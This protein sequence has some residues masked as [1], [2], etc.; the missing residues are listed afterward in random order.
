MPA[1]PIEPLVPG[2]DVETVLAASWIGRDAAR[3]LDS[4]EV[5]EKLGLAEPG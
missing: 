5:R 1:G 2:A 3:E 4:A